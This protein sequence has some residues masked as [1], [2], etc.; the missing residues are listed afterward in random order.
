M[1][2]VRQASLT[3]A[4]TGRG[5]IV[6]RG[7]AGQTPEGPGPSNRAPSRLSPPC[8]QLLSPPNRLFLLCQL[9]STL[10]LSICYNLHG[11]SLSA[12]QAA[13][14]ALRPI[15]RSVWLRS[16][17]PPLLPQRRPA[18]SRRPDQLCHLLAHKLAKR[19][20]LSTIRKMK[21]RHQSATRRRV[22]PGP[23]SRTSALRALPVLWLTMA[24]K[25]TLGR[26]SGA[27]GQPS[28]AQSAGD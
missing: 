6:P 22:K 19:P 3:L 24:P 10:I 20:K 13:W 23:I 18:R 7:R 16:V 8:D 27:G 25:M 26:R 1:S 21:A 28:T 4:G 12:R 2:G 14:A 17:P 5:S 9:A 15:P 11:Q